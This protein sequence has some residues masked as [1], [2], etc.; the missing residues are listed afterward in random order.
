M[1]FC[2]GIKV[3]NFKLHVQSDFR[4][5][6]TNCRRKEKKT[7]KKQTKQTKHSSRKKAQMDDPKVTKERK[8]IYMNEFYSQLNDSV[9]FW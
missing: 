2:A 5:L 8:I 6:P 4:V 1:Y 3:I 9:T 7:K